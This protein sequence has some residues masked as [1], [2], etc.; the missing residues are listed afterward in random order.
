MKHENHGFSELVAKPAHEL[1]HLG[2]VIDVEVVGGFV[3]E[4]VLGVLREHHSNKGALALAA[5]HFVDEAFSEAF[6]L[7]VAD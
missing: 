1:H 3:K 4:H 7:H 2:G 6:E 5:R